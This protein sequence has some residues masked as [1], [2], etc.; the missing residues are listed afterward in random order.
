M[1][2]TVRVVKTKALISSAVTAKLIC[3]FVVAYAD[4]WFSHA[5]AQMSHIMR[6]VWFGLCE[7]KHDDPLR[8]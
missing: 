1:N 5:M 4:C 6:K 7:I 2:F 8:I 3:T